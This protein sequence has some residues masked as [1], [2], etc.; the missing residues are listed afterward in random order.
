MSSDTPDSSPDR[1]NDRRDDEPR[2]RRRRDY[3]DE[4]RQRRPRYDDPPQLPQI[5]TLGLF[6]LI[7]GI[8]SL[9]AS[10]IPCIGVLGIVGGAFGLLLGAIGIVLAKKSNGQTG[11]GL[12]IAG[13]VVNVFAMLIG[14][15]WLLIMAAFFQK[16]GDI[17]VVDP[18]A[19]VEI[20]AVALD[21]EYDDDELDADKKYKGKVLVVTGTIKK[22]TRDDRPGKITLELNGTT[23]STVDC[24][25]DRDKQADLGTVGVGQEI[26]VRGTCKGKV[27][28]WV[29]LENCSLDK[30]PDGKTDPKGGPPLAAI[31]VT[32]EE[33]DRAYE[34]NVVA[35]DAKYKGKVLHLTGQVFKIARNKPSVVTI[36]FETEAG[37]TIDCDFPKDAQA[38]LAMVAPG[39]TIIVRGTCRG[40]SD[41]DIVS[42]SN[43]TLVEK[44]TKPAPGAPVEVTAEELAKAYEGNVVSAD[45]SYK[46][47]FLEVS[48]KVVRVARN[49]PGKITVYLGAE[50]RFTVACDFLAKDGQAQL[51]AVEAG[52][53]VVI[54]GTCKGGSEGIPLLENCSL[55]KK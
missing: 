5:S 40:R 50:D 18:G 24:H 12:P 3:D 20:T 54:R 4:P 2:P 14:G 51:A 52:A 47:K 11:P 7:Q 9:I 45:K 43:C 10:F 21:T 16:A 41:D 46:G 17:P 1:D 27:R 6:S 55:V 34:D 42:L 29:T 37:D 36:E 39:D 25:F 33:L 53:A 13:I 49:K 15:A 31:P 48:G 38:P 26:T 28:T 30:K 35:A 19:G 44:V 22:I 32:A 23:D 8:G